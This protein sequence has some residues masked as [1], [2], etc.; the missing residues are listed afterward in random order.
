VAIVHLEVQ[1]SQRLF[2][3]QVTVASVSVAPTDLVSA[4][5]TRV[6]EAARAATGGAALGDVVVCRLDDTLGEL[7]GSNM[8]CRPSKRW[9]TSPGSRPTQS[10]RRRRAMRL[11]AVSGVAGLRIDRL[12]CYDG[13]GCGAACGWR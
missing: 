13:G 1:V 12:L 9:A 11:P 4:A 2:D 7:G 10:R 6:V 8:V 3:K 5:L